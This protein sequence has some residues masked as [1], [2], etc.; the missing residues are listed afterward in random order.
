MIDMAIDAGQTSFPGGGD[1]MA[2]SVVV[3]LVV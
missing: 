1:C 2:R 3:L